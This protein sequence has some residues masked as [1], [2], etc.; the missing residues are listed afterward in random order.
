VSSQ[1]PLDKARQRLSDT[2]LVHGA[3]LRWRAGGGRRG[4][5]RVK[6]EGRTMSLGRA[7]INREIH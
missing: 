5:S 7:L 6:M 1:S 4:G 3:E 2:T